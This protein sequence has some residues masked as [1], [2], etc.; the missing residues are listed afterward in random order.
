MKTSARVAAYVLISALK[1]YLKLISTRLTQKDIIRQAVQMLLNAL[2]AHSAL[3]FVQTWL[4]RFLD[5]RTTWIL[6]LK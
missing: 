5:R 4:L 2:D 3:R 6:N 1:R